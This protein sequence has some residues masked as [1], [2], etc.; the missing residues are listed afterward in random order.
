MRS[1]RS[2]LGVLALRVLLGAIFGSVI[3]YLLRGLW[4]PLGHDY[5][6]LGSPTSAPLRIGL[7]VFGITIGA[8]L[9]LNLGGLIGVVVGAMR[10]TKRGE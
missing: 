9:K 1:R 3:G 6:S 7:G 8:W 10:P 4:S 5:I 2:G